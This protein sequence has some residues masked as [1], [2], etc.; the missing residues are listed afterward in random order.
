MN[1]YE[2]GDCQPETPSRSTRR[3][4]GCLVKAIALHGIGLYIYAGED[5]PAG[6]DAKGDMGKDADRSEVERGVLDF[7]TAFKSGRTRGRD[8]RGRHARPRARG[9]QC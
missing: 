8:R 6:S 4:S 3:C 1:H 9:D 2:Q 5:L 7:R